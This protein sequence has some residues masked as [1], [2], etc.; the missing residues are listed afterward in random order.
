MTGFAAIKKEEIVM[1]L[2]LDG[3]R[4]NPIVLL[5]VF[6]VALCLVALVGCSN[7]DNQTE[8]EQSK[9]AEE[10]QQLTAENEKLHTEL[11]ETN[12][13]LK[14]AEARVKELEHEL[15]AMREAQAAPSPTASAKVEITPS[16]RTPSELLLGQ[17]FSREF[18]E[19]G[20]WSWIQTL[21]FN[22]D[23]T[24]TISQTYYI[25]KAGAEDNIIE[26]EDG[27]YLY[28]LIDADMEDKFSWRLDGDTLHMDIGNGESADFAYSP[29]QQ[30]L[31]LVNGSNAYGRNMPSGMDEYVERALYSESS[32]AKEAKETMRRRRFLGV[33]YYDVLTWTFN[34]DGTGIWDI[35]ELG[36]QPAEKRKFTYSVADN[37][38]A[39][40]YLC[41]TIDW[42]DSDYWMLFPTFNADGS[43]SLMG[44]G[45]TEPVMKWTHT[46]DADNCPISAKIIS[47]GIDVISGRMFYDMLGIEE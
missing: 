13:E 11:D 9:A 23:G 1:K 8:A 18:H 42:D 34:E 26:L 16:E 47:N 40:D 45:Q 7:G 14:T 33:W 38:G 2:Y 21:I 31:T 37:G 4:K 15:E 39:G 20:V 30:T 35:P 19:D 41:L 27:T 43:M 10:I 17:W 24:G 12:D 28:L 29:D 5:K 22:S 25:P 3:F 36:D 32:E 44:A 46:F 6:G